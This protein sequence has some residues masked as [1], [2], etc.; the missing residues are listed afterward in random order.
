[1]L[2]RLVRL[3]LHPDRVADFLALFEQSRARILAQPG[4]RHLALW[5]D[6]DAPA[7]YCTYSHWTDAAALEAYRR[8]ALFGQVWPAT[9]RLL[10]SPAL[11]FS[12]RE[13][14]FESV[15]VRT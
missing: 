11:A 9:K 1:M 10:A 3:P 8:S 15:D 5:Q 6:M 2:I 12:V 13:V 4:C 7:T 14:G